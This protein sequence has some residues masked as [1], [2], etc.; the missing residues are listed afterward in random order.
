[1][2]RKSIALLVPALI[3]SLLLIVPSPVAAASGYTETG[4]ATY[5]VNTENSRIDVS[6][7]IKFVNNK[8]P[9]GGLIYYYQNT[10][11]AVE[12]QAGTVKASA[13]VGSVKQSVASSSRWY[14]YINL[15]FSPVYYRQ[16]RVINISYSIDGAP[17]AD[18]DYR[19]VKA[20]ANLCA[21]PQGHD[22]GVVKI[23]LPSD[24]DVTFY[25]GEE[26]QPVGTSG[27]LTTYS[28]PSLSEPRTH[29][30][31]MDASN[32]D[33]LVKTPETVNGQK[34]EI[35]SWP[36][37][38]AWKAMIE[39]ELAGDIKGLQEMNGLDL[40]GGTIVVR[41]VG[42][43]ELGEYA[44][45]YNSLTKIAYVTEDT[46][47][48][49]IAHELSHIWYNRNLFKDK[50]AS[51]GLAGYSEKLAGV[52]NYTACKAPGSYP[53]TGKPDLVAWVVLDFTS[54]TTDQQILDY[55]YAAACYIITELAADMGDASFK[56]VLEAGSKGLMAYQGATVDE[57]APAS[58]TPL[59]SE[60]FLDL[61]DEMGM[62]PGG[63][64]DLDQAQ[65]LLAKYGIF[66]ATDLA[67]RSKAR[68][69]Y[70]ALADQ[71]GDW[72][73]PLVVR[74]QMGRW[75]FDAADMAL[76]SAQKIIDARDAMEGELKDVSFTG[77]KLQAQFQN[78]ATADD[79]STL[80]DLVA[81]ESDAAK[82]VAEAQKAESGG[83]N[84][85]QMLGLLGSD[86]H[87]PMNQAI[88]DLKNLKPDEAKTS[89]QN[90]IDTV[91]G[92]TM[93][94]LL[95]ILLVVGVAVVAF[96]AFLLFRT[97]RR[98]R[99]EAAALALATAEGGEAAVESAAEATAEP[100]KKRAPRKPKADAT[101]AEA[102]AT[103]EPVVKKGGSRAKV[104]ADEIA[105][106]ATAEAAA[107]PKTTRTRA[108]AADAA[109]EA[110]EAAAPKPKATRAKAKAADTNEPPSA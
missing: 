55:Q 6:I 108:K 36:E 103:A 58:S 77:T 29:W 104:K 16:T 12:A 92:G 52:G 46:G 19:A 54:S 2:R 49:I 101:V 23:V 83:Q 8:P 68:A 4:T 26:L 106:D 107:K 89:A 38:T 67:A 81:K 66:D 72:K 84:P 82:V 96:L 110:A 21:I 90:V 51:E 78:V 50:W 47:P 60:A 71:A 48:D 35:Q 15:T 25:S 22:S 91:N 13:N 79:L 43:S 41:E 17:H 94:G 33:A 27:G 100:V 39:N 64:E 3:A 32:P 93:G 11:I 59:S 10:Q 53:G 95:R 61:I 57:K 30:T 1:V 62:I 97:M 37:D 109:V 69:S 65:T 73:M 31:C 42:N 88:D 86:V 87:T 102:V 34:F 24:F 98:R 75:N 99:A 14:K 70:H 44:G 9:S 74:D 76:T 45:L 56:A 40:P 7:Q 18:G 63:V 28:S 20:Y 105:A 80:A 5:V 85:L